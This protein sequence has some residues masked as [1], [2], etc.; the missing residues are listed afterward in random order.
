[1]FKLIKINN[2]RINVPEPVRLTLG[3]SVTLER[4]TPVI[5]KG[6]TLS[7]VTAASE[8]L[9]THVTLAPV[10][11]T[12]ALVYELTP[13]AVLEVT[14]SGSP[15]ALTVGEEY[16]LTSD[17]KQLSTTAASGTK[18]GARLVSKTGAVSAGD[19]VLIRFR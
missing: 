5:L 15:T 19:A 8:A 14:V 6:G 7:A 16:L 18:R 12:E 13:D 1:M 9:P 10:N 4:G 2:A 3:S 11:G 17:G